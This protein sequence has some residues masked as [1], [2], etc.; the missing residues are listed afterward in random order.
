MA[1]FEQGWMTGSWDTSEVW[2]WC[3]SRG[4]CRW[5]YMSGVAGMTW[6]HGAIAGITPLPHKG[7]EGAKMRG[8]KKTHCKN[9]DAMSNDAKPVMSNFFWRNVRV[10]AMPF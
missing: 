9:G 10:D 3:D 8:A 1:S 4:Y 2:W 6:G 7:V 5:K